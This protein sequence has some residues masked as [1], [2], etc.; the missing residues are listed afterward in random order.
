[1]SVQ[2][3]LMHRPLRGVLDGSFASPHARPRFPSGKGGTRICVCAR[4]ERPAPHARARTH[5][6]VFLR[7]PSEGQIMQRTAFPRRLRFDGAEMRF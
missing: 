5:V 6:A 7:A 3:A 2:L 4:D 1:M